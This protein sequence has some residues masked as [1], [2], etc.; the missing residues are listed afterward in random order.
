MEVIKDYYLF[1]AWGIFIGGYLTIVIPA[2][3]GLF[4]SPYTTYKEDYVTGLK[5]HVV[6][7]VII[8]IV[9]FVFSVI[10]LLNYYLGGSL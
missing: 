2:I 3:G 4:G 10:Y 6:I 8:S 1:I 9:A 7:V 5:L